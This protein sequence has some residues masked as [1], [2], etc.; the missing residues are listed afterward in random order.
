MSTRPAVQFEKLR[1]DLAESLVEFDLQ[2]NQDGM[3]G[4]AIAPVIEVGV[5]RGDYPVIELKELLKKRDTRRR[6]DGSYG[7]GD[8][9]GNKDIFSTEEH[10]FEEPVDERE[11]AVFG[12]WWDAEQLAADRSRDAVLSNF[13][14]RIVAAATDTNVVTQTAAASVAWSSPA[15]ATPITDVKTGR[16]AVRNATGCVPNCLAI[17]WEAFEHLRD[18][19]QII[20]RLKYSGH[21]N[22]NRDNITKAVLAQALGLDEVIVSGAIYNSANE[23]QAASLATQWPKTKA[24]LFTRR[25]DRNTKRPRFMNTFHW[26]ADGSKIGG[27]FDYYYDPARRRWIVRNR[28][29]TDEKVVYPELGY[30]ITGV[31]S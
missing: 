7:R 13:N 30:I 4:L 24:L 23:A 26:G 14:D 21:E 22:P 2:A 27:V 31:L 3:I 29:E 1:P 28:L 11:A 17:D 20:D 25:T 8:G 18:C 10:G 12:D 16:I 5:P 15:T 6:S 19:A 9:E